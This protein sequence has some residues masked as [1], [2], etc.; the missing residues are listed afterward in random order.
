M[1]TA[2]IDQTLEDEDIVSRIT[3]GEIGLF[4]LLI[5]RYNPYLYKVGRSYGFNHQDTEDLMQESFIDSYQHLA[6]LENKAAFRFWL[7]KIMLNKCNKKSRTLTFQRNVSTDV[8]YLND[9]PMFSGERDGDATSIIDK[10]EIGALIEK[11]LMR[12]PLDYR[13]VFTMREMNG[14]NVE[15]TAKALNISSVNV[16]V[17]LNR[18]KA[19]L[20]KEI[21]KVYSS[22]ELFP[23]NLIYCDQVVSNVM[24]KITGS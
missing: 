22:E 4:E 5:R 18:A 12:V 14:F 8:L 17:R 16:R 6:Q 7:L 11:A 10:R 15:E 23:F 24:G 9:I 1:I 13:L 21:E 20:R 3:Y 2:G 19:L